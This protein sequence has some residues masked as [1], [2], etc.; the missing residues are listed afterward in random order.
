M[1][2]QLGEQNKKL[3]SLIER[4]DDSA[5]SLTLYRTIV[6]NGMDRDATFQDVVTSVKSKLMTDIPSLNRAPQV[7]RSVVLAARLEEAS[8]HIYIYIYMC[9]YKYMYICMRMSVYICI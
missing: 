3:R 4:M 5:Q 7:E 2:P 8:Q 9:E 1:V 6:S